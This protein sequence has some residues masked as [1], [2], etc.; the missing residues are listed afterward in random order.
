VDP[1]IPQGQQLRQWYETE[2]RAL[3]STSISTRG[4]GGMG[5]GGGPMARKYLGDIKDSNLG[6][7]EKPDMFASKATI[8][9]IRAD[10]DKPPYYLS[11]ETCK[12]KAQED[13]G[14]WSCAFCHKSFPVPKPRYILSCQIADATGSTWATLFD[15]DATSIIGIDAVTCKSLVDSKNKVEFDKMFRKHAFRSFVFRLKAKAEQE[16]DAVRWKVS[17]LKA[18]PIDFLAESR[19][20]LAE[21]AKYGN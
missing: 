1:E 5:G 19:A 20:M 12:R 6:F 15:D 17:V 7:N 2:G 13:M 18:D 10:L 9:Y 16:N 14:N 3:E 8:S 11:C 21:I 4:G